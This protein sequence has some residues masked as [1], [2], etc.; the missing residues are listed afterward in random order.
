MLFRAFEN[1]FFG[2]SNILL[3]RHPSTGLFEQ[4]TVAS[5]SK[6]GGRLLLQE[7]YFIIAF[8][9]LLLHINLI[10]NFYTCLKG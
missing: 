8:K 7:K 2:A 10:L 1:N 4:S 5:S 3:S 9:F 6:A